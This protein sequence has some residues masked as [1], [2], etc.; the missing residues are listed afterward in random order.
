MGRD[1]TVQE[2]SE[3]AGWS[4]RKIARE[5]V[6]GWIERIPERMQAVLDANGGP[7]KW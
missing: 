3:Q 4:G 5:T 6:D 7:T 1:H 2:L